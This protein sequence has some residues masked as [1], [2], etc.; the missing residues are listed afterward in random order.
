M[1]INGYKQHLPVSAADRVTALVCHAM[2]HA[3]GALTAELLGVGVQH[4]DRGFVLRAHD[5]LD[6]LKVRRT[7][8]TGKGLRRRFL[9]NELQD[10]S[11][12]TLRRK[13]GRQG[14]FTAD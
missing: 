8:E 3:R 14:F 10:F 5:G 2:L 4:R 6:W 1:V 12:P 13:N 9:L 7:R 11:M